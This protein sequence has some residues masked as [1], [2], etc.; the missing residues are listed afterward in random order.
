MTCYEHEKYI[1]RFVDIV[2]Q[3][4][5]DGFFLHTVH[6]RLDRLAHDE[7]RLRF[8]NRI[9][10]NIREYLDAPDDSRWTRKGFVYMMKRER[11]K[12]LAQKIT[13]KWMTWVIR[14]PA[15]KEAHQLY[16]TK[17]DETKREQVSAQ[18]GESGNVKA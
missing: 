17:K 1:D 3:R 4:V 7:E 8:E 5:Y 6:T 2:G 11:I 18:S 10:K 14:Q 13:N 15:S 16:L 12:P 9:R